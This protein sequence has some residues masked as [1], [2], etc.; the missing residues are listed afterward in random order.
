MWHYPFIIEPL[1]LIFTQAP[2]AIIAA[3]NERFD[4]HV[5]PHVHR[6][7]DRRKSGSLSIPDH[8]IFLSFICFYFQVP[9]TVMQV[10]EFFRVHELIMFT[11]SV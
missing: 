2:E 10:V 6:M 1:S 4:T 11:L 9:K 3:I 7:N 8:F 5:D